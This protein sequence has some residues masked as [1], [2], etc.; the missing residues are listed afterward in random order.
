MHEVVM[1]RGMRRV[2]TGAKAIWSLC[3]RLELGVLT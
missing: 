2:M 1:S 3:E